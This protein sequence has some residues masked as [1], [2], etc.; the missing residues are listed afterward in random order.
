MSGERPVPLHRASRITTLIGCTLA[1]VISVGGCGDGMVASRR[2][3]PREYAKCVQTRMQHCSA[4]V[5]NDMRSSSLRALGVD[6]MGRALAKIKLAGGE[7]IGIVPLRR[8]C[9][10]GNECYEELGTVAEPLK[11]REFRGIRHLVTLPSVDGP[12]FGR[13]SAGERP[14]GPL[15][16]VG[17]SVCVGRAKRGRSAELVYGILRSTQDKVF[18]ESRGGTSRFRE[19]GIAR[20]LN[21]EGALV[22]ALLPSGMNVVLVKNQHG[23]AVQ[24]VKWP[25]GAHQGSC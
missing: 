16:V 7:T 11:Y 14:S 20:D 24:R 18:D 13:S 12:Q 8:G 19:I 4:R 9:F 5:L 6:K 2:A 21:A 3:T 17:E 22:Y 10:H 23:R 25:V 15:D 1:M